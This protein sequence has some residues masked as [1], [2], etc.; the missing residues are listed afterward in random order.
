M[1]LNRVPH[2]FQ[3]WACMQVMDIA[4]ANGNRPWEKDV[5]LLCSSCGHVCETCLRIL[6]CNHTGCLEALNHSV[7]LL[8]KWLIKVDTDPNL[9]ACIVEYDQGQGGISMTEICGDMDHRYPKMAEEQ[10]AVGWRCFMKSMLC[11]VLRNLQEMYLA[12]EG[13]KITGEQWADGVIIPRNY[14]RPVAI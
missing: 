4:P 11:H 6:F 14:T 12:F 8:E 9:H 5:C 10:D 13:L 3:I 2:M 1:A 7:D